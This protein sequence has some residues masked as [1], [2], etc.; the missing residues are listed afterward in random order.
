M[1]DPWRLTTEAMAFWWRLAETWT[2]ASVTIA[3]RTALMSSAMLPGESLPW[4]EMVRMVEEK[5]RAAII[6]ANSMLTPYHRATRRNAHRLT[7][8]R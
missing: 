8:G 4:A 5:Q 1:T 2:Y 7:R 6:A 3:A